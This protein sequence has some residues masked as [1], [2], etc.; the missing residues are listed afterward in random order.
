MNSCFPRTPFYKE[1]AN[2]GMIDSIDLTSH[3]EFLW[4]MGLTIKK[5]EN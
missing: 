5:R 3:L 1:N 4:N 2:G